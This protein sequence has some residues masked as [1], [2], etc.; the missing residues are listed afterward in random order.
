LDFIEIKRIDTEVDSPYITKPLH[1]DA[2]ARILDASDQ[3]LY[4]L[5]QIT[6]DK[7]EL[8]YFAELS[9]KDSEYSFSAYVKTS[10]T[11]GGGARE[12]I[13]NLGN[14][15]ALLDKRPMYEV[16]CSLSNLYTNKSIYKYSHKVTT[17]CQVY[18]SMELCLQELNN[19]L[20]V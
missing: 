16:K 5:Y 2:V 12:Q 10:F 14:N 17:Q 19:K 9:D 20:N 3:T 15:K 1:K 13:K 11:F 7:K 18:N 4:R 8:N 6:N